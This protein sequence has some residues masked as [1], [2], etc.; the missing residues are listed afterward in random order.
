MSEAL[1]S[2][3]T[4]QPAQRLWVLER[5]AASLRAAY[6]D[7]CRF[8]GAVAILGDTCTYVVFVRSPE[9]DRANEGLLREVHLRLNIERDAF[10]FSTLDEAVRWVSTAK[11]D[12]AAPRLDDTEDPKTADA[13][14]VATRPNSAAIPFIGE[15]R[16]PRS[17]R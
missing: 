14:G 4:T 3:W 5:D 8:V 13:N 12:M 17:S 16:D 1:P 2:A 11:Q 10:R 7:V 9:M 15:T 6:E